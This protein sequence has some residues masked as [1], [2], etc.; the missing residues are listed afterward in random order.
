MSYSHFSTSERTKLELLHAQGWSTRVIAQE[1]GRHHSSVAR[2]L[3][4]NQES[5]IYKADRAQLA[6]EQRRRCTSSFSKQTT[7]RIE[8]ISERLKATWSP[9]QIAGRMKIEFPKLYV[10]FKTSYRWL[11]AGLLVQGF[12]Q[13]LRLKESVE[14]LQKHAESSISARPSA[15]VL[16]RYVSAR[17]LVIG[18]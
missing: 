4:R 16:K 1:L 6:Y 12:V 13:V 8:Y 10:C 15:N 9:E 18:S 7:D 11:Y 2:E 5:N 14:S 17:A 3:N